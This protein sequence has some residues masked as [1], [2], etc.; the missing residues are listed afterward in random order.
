MEQLRQ[1]KS[2]EIA[3]F[4][5]Y[6]EAD[7]YNVFTEVTNEKLIDA[8]LACT[9]LGEGAVVADLGSSAANL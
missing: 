1:N 3:F 4:D 8:F 7:D 9:G 6:A 2:W 5:R